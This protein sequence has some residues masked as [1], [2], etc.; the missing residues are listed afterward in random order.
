MEPGIAKGN[1][2][3]WPFHQP[4]WAASLWMPFLGSLMW[5]FGMLIGLGWSVEAIG[6]LAR[7]PAHSLPRSRDLA[8]I[9]KH[10][11]VVIVAIIFYFVIPLLILSTVFEFR[12]VTEIWDLIVAI[13]RALTHSSQKSLSATIIETL[14]KL[15]ANSAAPIIYLLIA[16]PLFFVARLRYALTGHVRSFFNVFGNIY[17]C[18]RSAGEILLYLFFGAI[19]RGVIAIILAVVVGTV[20]GTII[21]IALGAANNWILS[22]LAAKIA[23]QMYERDRI[24]V[25]SHHGSAV[26]SS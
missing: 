20:V 23:K 19:T 25:P 9:L 17:V 26:V 6:G 13:W 12:W 3:T 10:G 11:L 7:S 24:G 21:P 22:Y 1:L 8:R 4:R 15:L 16:T 18:F 14:V 5:P 2:I